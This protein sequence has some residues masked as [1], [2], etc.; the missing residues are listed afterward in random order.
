MFSSRGILYSESIHRIYYIIMYAM[1]YL[2]IVHI[3]GVFHAIHIKI[4]FS[5]EVH[6]LF[7]NT[8]YFN[9]YKKIKTYSFS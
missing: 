8:L 9:E 3:I 6:P 7:Q 1:E 2:R 4:Y 5:S